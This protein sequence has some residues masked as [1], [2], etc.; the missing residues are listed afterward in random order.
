MRRFFKGLVG[1][2]LESIIS[3]MGE[4]EVAM[5]KLDDFKF[6]G[7]APLSFKFKERRA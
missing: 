7:R 1:A 5:G 6:Q 4:I 2:V 3:R